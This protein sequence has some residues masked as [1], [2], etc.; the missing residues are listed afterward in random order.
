MTNA[1]QAPHITKQRLDSRQDQPS[2]HIY[3]NVSVV[4]ENGKNWVLS[5]LSNSIFNRGRV[6]P[7]L[8]PVLSNLRGHLQPLA[9]AREI[10]RR[11]REASITPA[12]LRGQPSS[13]AHPE[14]A[15][16]EGHQPGAEQE[17]P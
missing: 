10:A 3:G 13:W 5:R 1:V 14:V 17:D 12:F 4:Y 9:T 16:T 11:V 8:E 15:W 2:L 7:E 6:H